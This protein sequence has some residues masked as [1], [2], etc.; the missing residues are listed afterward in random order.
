MA[1]DPDP[2]PNINPVKPL[3]EIPFVDCNNVLNG[4][5]YIDGWCNKCV[6]G[7]TG[8]TRCAPVLDC[9]SVPGGTAYID[10]CGKCV[11]GNTG[12]VPCADCT[13]STLALTTSTTSNSATAIPT[14]G[15]SPYTF[16]WSNGSTSDTATDLVDGTYTVN[17]TDNQKC[18]KVGTAIISQCDDTT[19]AYPA[20]TIGGQVWM[21]KNLNVCKYRNGDD[22]PQVQDR[23]EW[24]ALTTGAWCYY[25]NNTANGPVYGKLYNWYA[26]NDPRGLAPAGWHVPSDVE[27]TTLTTFLGGELFAGN[28]MKATTGWTLTSG[29]T[30]TNSSGFTGLP[31]GYRFNDGE[32]YY[33]GNNGYWWSS[34]EAGTT[35][36]WNRYLGYFYGDVGRGRN[37]SNKNSGYSVRCLK[38]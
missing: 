25:A 24:Y 37:N 11:A 14:G 35:D 7:N 17:V 12:N 27:W 5:A 13:N 38:D 6:E 21:Q 1:E 34:L 28:K 22:I 29:I 26:V 18:T 16:V 8:L 15:Q 31:G 4:S 9:N 36:L 20:V 3:G 30:N 33:V 10:N 32:F 19:T 23:T 2:N